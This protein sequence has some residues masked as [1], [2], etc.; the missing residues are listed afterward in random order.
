LQ[1]KRVV[2]LDGVMR[3]QLDEK[4]RMGRGSANLEAR[5]AVL[6]VHRAY[7]ETG[8][9]IIGANCGALDPLM[10]AR[11][12][13]TLRAATDRPIAAQPNAGRPRLVEDK[14]VF[15]MEPAAFADGVAACIRAGARTVGGCCGTGP[16]HPRAVC[17]RIR[18]L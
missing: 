11:A 15:D 1:D 9:D 18:D 14:T 6:E 17:E 10:M 5:Q 13:A 8:A 3:T 16:D 2:V 12:V 7:V 4:G